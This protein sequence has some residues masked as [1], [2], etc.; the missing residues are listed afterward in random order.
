MKEARRKDQLIYKKIKILAD[1]VNYYDEVYYNKNTQVV[2]DFEYDKLRNEL[3]SLEKKYP[4]LIVKDSPSNKVGSTPSKSFDTI[5]HNSPM[6]S[7]NNAYDY[8]D[9]ISFYKKNKKILKKFDILAETKVD[10]L[11]ASLRYK[12]R[13]LLKAVTRGDG[14]FGE[15]ITNN[16]FYVNGV[17][18]IL[19]DNFPADLEIRGEIFMPKTVFNRINESRINNGKKTYPRLSI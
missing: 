3:K 14:A 12:N 9:V 19:P 18:H 10:G 4:H 13:K 17:K 15:D 6:L 7:L 1:K 11:S 16:I 2:S 5:Q 8:E